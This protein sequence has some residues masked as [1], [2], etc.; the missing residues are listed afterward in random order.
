MTSP[1]KIG[2]PAPSR[3]TRSARRKIV[4]A[5]GLGLAALL[6]FDYLA[7]ASDGVMAILSRALVATVLLAG[8]F[9]LITTSTWF[10]MNAPDGALDERERALRGRV[11]FDAYATLAGVVA[12]AAFYFATFGPDFELWMPQTQDQWWTIAWA[13]IALAML[14][15]TALYA[16][17]APDPLVDEI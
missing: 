13:G 1:A 14:L 6:V 3:L 11:Y 7:S 12:F 2:R 16:W 10:M 8:I 9:A 15:P 5:I 17:R 4:A